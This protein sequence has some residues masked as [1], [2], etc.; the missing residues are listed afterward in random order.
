MT[1]IHELPGWPDCTREGTL[2]AL[3]HKQGRHLGKMEHQYPR[4]EHHNA[5]I[6]TNANT[7]LTFLFLGSYIRKDEHGYGSRCLP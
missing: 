6:G 1:S 5:I 4:T 3:R 7:L 2:A